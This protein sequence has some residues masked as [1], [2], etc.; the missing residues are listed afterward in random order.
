MRIKN[1]VVV[2]L[3][4]KYSNMRTNLGELDCGFQVSWSWWRGID[5][6]FHGVGKNKIGVPPYP[7]PFKIARNDW[8][9]ITSRSMAAPSALSFASLFPLPCHLPN[10]RFTDSIWNYLFSM[11]RNDRLMTISRFTTLLSWPTTL[12]GDSSS[13]SVSLKFDELKKLLIKHSWNSIPLSNRIFRLHLEPFGT[14]FFNV[15]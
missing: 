12:L 14:F 1:V 15:L 4:V 11:Y 9:V 5:W 2:D 7:C 3:T 6:G 8:F 13:K 10:N